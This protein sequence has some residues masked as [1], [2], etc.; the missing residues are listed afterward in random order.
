M[1]NKSRHVLARIR[2]R[3]FLVEAVPFFSLEAP[4]WKAKALVWKEAG[5]P[6]GQ[7]VNCPAEAIFFTREHAVQ[8]S[9]FLGRE[10]VQGQ[11]KG[12]RQKPSRKGICKPVKFPGFVDC[13]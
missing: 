3:E 10:W 8:A 5:E 6:S 1:A 9:L 13:L 7:F 4:G 2:C 12:A 11:A